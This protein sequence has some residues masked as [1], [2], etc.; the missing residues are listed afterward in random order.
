MTLVETD[1]V[2]VEHFQTMKDFIK[3][4]YTFITSHQVPL[5]YESTNLFN[6]KAYYVSNV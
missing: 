5:H 6:Y 3:F 2:K 1:Y 4:D